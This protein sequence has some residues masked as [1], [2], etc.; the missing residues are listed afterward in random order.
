MEDIYDFI[1]N[2]RNK[3]IEK[4]KN[5]FISYVLKQN[6]ENTI[7]LKIFYIVESH[8]YPANWNIFSIT[9][10]KNYYYKNIYPKI[11]NLIN[12]EYDKNEDT[13][14]IIKNNLEHKYK[15]AELQHE[16]NIKLAELQHEEKLKLADIENRKIELEKMKLQFEMF[17]A[18][19]KL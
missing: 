14:S 10:K 6:I 17:K 9:T 1:I 19:F 8:N 7:I 16:E 4:I 18:G 3:N 2:S 13:K 12:N 5:Y 15:L 11:I